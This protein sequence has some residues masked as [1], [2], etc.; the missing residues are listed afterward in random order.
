MAISETCCSSKAYFVEVDNLSQKFGYSLAKCRHIF[1]LALPNNKNTPTET[2]QSRLALRVPSHV[3]LKLALPIGDIDCR[4]RSPLAAWM[5]VPKTTIHKNYR[6][7]LWQNN[8]G[9]A[10]KILSVKS[11]T[12]AHAMQEGA[13]YFFWPCVAT[14][15]L[16]HDPT[17]S[18]RA[19]PV[20]SKYY[21]T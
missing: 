17:A 21:S 4:S 16:R 7:K 3:S 15:H 2:F 10:G 13:Y 5:T 19:Y 6:V 8:I 18:F 11:K 12:V 1:K 9:I 20:H 14:F